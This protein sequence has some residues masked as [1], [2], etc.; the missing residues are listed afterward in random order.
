VI[1][2]RYLTA[3]LRRRKGRTILTSLGL[4]VGVGLVAT[5]VALSNGLDD[6][7][8]KVFAP[9]T[10][11]GT[12]MSVSR[13]VRF[14]GSGGAQSF[15]GAGLSLEEQQQ[16]QAENAPAFLEMN[17]LR[18]TAGERFARDFLMTTDRLSFPEREARAVASVPGV[19]AIA[20][21]LTLNFFRFSG[22]VPEPGASLDSVDVNQSTISGIDTPAPELAL[23]T[24]TQITRG[25]YF[26]AGANAPREAVV[27]RDYANR[28]RL[29]VGDTLK[30]RDLTFTIIGIATPPLGSETSDIVVRLGVLQQLAKLQGRVNVLRARTASA[31]QLGR[32]A[33]RI[34]QNFPGYQ[35]ATSRD[36]AGRVSGSLKDAKSLSGKLGTALA[37]VALAASILIA[38]L[39]TLSSVSKRTRELGTLKAIGWRK[40]LVV[41]QVVGESLA[42]GMLGG[43]L[44]ALLAV[45]GAGLISALGITVQASVAQT[46]E[47][48]PVAAPV[49]IFGQGRVAAGSSSIVLS[50]PIELPMLALAIALALLAGLL[51][52]A[53]GATRAA[54][55]RPAEALRTLE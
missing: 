20:P 41:R 27:T 39:L 48:I 44:G 32:V 12:D 23:V 51:A 9:L 34:E 8:A 25:R 19:E 52:G 53:L 6:A 26:E 38:S 24:P 43:L 7:Q 10:G 2:L 14:S 21:A 45:A 54:R 29:S 47:Q 30:I 35:V 13:P 11:L 4:A 1:Y 22:T 40:R 15:G 3:E 36:L 42:Q 50:A 17:S 46:A 28:R 55:L 18:L 31:E 5:V 49:E 37:I 33:D 16:L